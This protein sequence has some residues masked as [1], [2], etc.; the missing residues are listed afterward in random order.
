MKIA[1]SK[2][3]LETVMAA[4][5]GYLLILNE[6]L[7]SFKEDEPDLEPFTKEYQ[8]GIKF[9]AQQRIEAQ[10]TNRLCFKID[11]KLREWE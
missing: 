6:H 1:F 8:E 9:I 4:L 7:E 2:D 3:E 11:K 5:E 10:M